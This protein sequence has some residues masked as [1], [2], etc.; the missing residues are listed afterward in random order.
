M[1]RRNKHR[2]ISSNEAFRALYIDF[3]GFMEESPSL[4]GIACEYEF[5]QVV[6]DESLRGA[7]DA[8]RLRLTTVQQVGRELEA[9][10]AREDRLIIGYSQHELQLLMTYGAIDIGARYRDARMTG[11]RWINRLHR[12]EVPSW[13]L[14]DLLQYMGYEA[15]TVLANG[16]VTKRLAAVRRGLQVQGGC[17]SALTPVQKAKWTKLLRYNRVDCLGM[18]DLVMRAAAE[19]AI[20]ANG[21][22]AR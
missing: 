14:L 6:L 7:A 22:S 17:Y 18:R 9:R 4:M 8:K 3:E 5:E 21:A 2:H 12:G 10:A 16:L 1:K 13:S 20:Q 19:L 15:P 11:R